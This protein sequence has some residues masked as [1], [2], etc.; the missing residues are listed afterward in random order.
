LRAV[1]EAAG[2]RVVRSEYL[3]QWLFGAKLVERARERLLGPSPLPTVPADPIN[4][5]LFRISV[6]EARLGGRF[7]PF[8]NTV[9][10]ILA[11]PPR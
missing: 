1:A 7:L 3:F 2:L 4:E 8:G 10:A 11:G 6:A 9:L 5:T